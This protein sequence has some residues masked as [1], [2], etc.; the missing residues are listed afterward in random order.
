[1]ATRRDGQRSR[2]SCGL[3]L[4][5]FRMAP[6]LACHFLEVWARSS[7]RHDASHV[8]PVFVHVLSWVSLSAIQQL[9]LTLHDP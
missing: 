4:V 9:R 3:D 7:W 5:D 8:Y 2:W 6:V 1:M